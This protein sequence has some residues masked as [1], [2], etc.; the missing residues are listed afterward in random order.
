MIPL[1]LLGVAMSGRM[2]ADALSIKMIL[3]GIFM[4]GLL[5]IA[6]I[7][8]GVGSCMCKRWARSLCLLLSSFW[9][10]CGSIGMV[11]T[12]MI[13]PKVL[14]HPPANVQSGNVP[15]GFLTVVMAI[16]TFINFI[17]FVAV[18]AVLVLFY[19]S[20]HVKAT[21]E[22]RDPKTRWTDL[23]PLP[24][25]GLAVMLGFSALGFPLTMFGYN[26]VMPVFGAHLSGIPSL[27]IVAVL[28]IAF[29]F[30]AVSAFKG[31]IIGWY[32]AIGL[33]LLSSSSY[34]VTIARVGMLKL[35]EEMGFPPSQI[36]RFREM[37]TFEGPGFWIMMALCSI[38]FIVFLVFSRKYFDEK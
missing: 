8:L 18:P 25:L 24:R 11:S 22:E 28:S 2:G 31:K 36:E 38:P 23:I 7:W 13:M 19:K 6:F 34:A 3:P 4:Y 33:Y 37:G 16:S 20:P 1:M 21:C 30:S 15:P 26:W 32:T 5:S 14:A 35:Y 12:L 29:G 9:L 10:G 17:I 27:A